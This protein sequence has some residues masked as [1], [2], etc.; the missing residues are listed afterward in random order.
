MFKWLKIQ[1]FRCFEKVR[2]EGLNRINVIVGDN[3]SGKTAFLEALFLMSGS[4]PEV[5]IKTNVWR[6][7]MGRELPVLNASSFA[8]LWRDMFRNFDTTR[9]ISLSGKDDVRGSR[10]LEIFFDEEEGMLPVEPDSMPF[11]ALRP[12]NFEYRIGNKKYPT[13]I[14]LNEKGSPIRDGSVE[15]IPSVFLAPTNPHPGDDSDRFTA[16]SKRNQIDEVINVLREEFPQIENLSLETHLGRNT[17][18]AKLR[19]MEEKVPVGLFSAGAKKLLSILLALAHGTKGILIIDELENGFHFT[20][21]PALWSCL[22][23]W[24]SKENFNT[25]I[26]I[27]THSRE[28]LKALL[29]TIDN[30]QEAISLLRMEKENGTSKIKISSGEKLR[31]ALKQE[32]EV[33]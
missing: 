17:I 5:I 1:N 28:C 31:A 15:G 19:S 30:A 32:V 12:I 33:R 4:Y 2:V 8:D 16:L 23:K 20:K 18:F 29:P 22:S 11:A 6:G 26:F 10:S 24:S 3:S 27:S 25:Q 14:R 9:T 21:L 13:Q 7:V